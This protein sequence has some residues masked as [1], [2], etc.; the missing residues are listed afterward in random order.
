[1]PVKL[2]PDLVNE[3]TSPPPVKP[4]VSIQQS[5]IAEIKE[6]VTAKGDTSR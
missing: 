2:T 5:E 6:Q 3:P 4:D 1:M